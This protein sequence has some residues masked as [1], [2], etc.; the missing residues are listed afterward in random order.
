MQGSEAGERSPF[1]CRFG[2]PWRMLV[3]IAQRGNESGLVGGI[4]ALQ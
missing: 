2:H 4:Q 1:E 3:D